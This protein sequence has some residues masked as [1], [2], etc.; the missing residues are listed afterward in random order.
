MAQIKVAAVDFSMKCTWAAGS[1]PKT[2]THTITFEYSLPTGANVVSSYLTFTA[3]NPLHGAS[4]RTVSINGGEAIQFDLNQTNTIPV[5]V[6]SNSSSLEATFKFKSYLN[7]SNGGT[8]SLKITDILLV[9]NYSFPSASFYLSSSSVC[10]GESVTAHVTSADI[11]LDH[12]YTVTLADYS[13][14][15]SVVPDVPTTLNM[16][17]SMLEHMPNTSTETV[18]VYLDTISSTGEILGST[19]VTLTLLCPDDVL[20]TMGEPIVTGINQKNGKYIQSI[21]SVT[22]EAT[23][24]AGAWGSSIDSIKISGGNFSGESPLTT[25]VL[26]VA[27]DI[28]F[29]VTAID[30]RGRSTSTA[31]TIT[32]VPYSA[33]SIIS[34][35]AERCDINN[36][37][38]PEGTYGHI[39]ISYTYYSDDPDN[40]LSMKLTYKPVDRSIWTS[41]YSGEAIAQNSPFLLSDSEEFGISEAFDIAVTITDSYGKSASAETSIGTAY[42]YMRWEPLNNIVSFGCYP[43]DNASKC[44]Q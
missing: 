14:T 25:G 38:N 3:G 10:A 26:H 6:D 37:A 27:G 34:F 28:E 36:Q 35:T 32:V 42:V 21:S 15:Y 17:M 29:T 41:A 12:R 40:V 9:I 24:V 1:S 33:P 8:G 31:V 11:S 2:Q 7:L 13:K 18:Y 44:I 20:P 23:D 16:E 30:S 43:M 4:P 39:R 22:I 5:S 19:V